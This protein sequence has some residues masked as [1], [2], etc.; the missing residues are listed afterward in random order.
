MRLALLCLLAAPA[1]AQEAQDFEFPNPLRDETIAATCANWDQVRAGADPRAM[2]V[3]AGVWDGQYVQP[4]VPGLTYDM[5][6]QMRTFFGPD[7]AFQQLQ[8]GCLRTMDGQQFCNTGQ[9]TGEWTARFAAD[10]QGVVIATM[11]AGSGISGAVLP[12]SCAAG[13]VTFPDADTMQ[14]ADGSVARRAP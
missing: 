12:Q 13:M 9:V 8:Q 1:V 4:G 6:V 11:S 14:G 3:A 7:G 2:A 5:P 10:G